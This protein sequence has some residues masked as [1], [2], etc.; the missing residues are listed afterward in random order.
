MEFKI[1]KQVFLNGLYKVQGIID[2]KSTLNVL[3]HVLITS[4]SDGIRMTSTD[5][6]V[7]LFGH[8]PSEVIQPGSMAVNGRSL[9]DVVKSL[10]ND[11]IH[12]RSLENHWVEVVC[13]RSRFRLTGI[14]SDDF[15]VFQQDDGIA[16]FT[17]DKAVIQS[18]IEK[19]GFSVS[20]DET[21]LNLNGVYFQAQPD[22]E[23]RLRLV[24][25]STDGHRLS[26]VEETVESNW[27][28][29]GAEAIIH[30]KGVFEL[31]R[32]LDGVD[33]QTQV[34]FHQANVVFKNDGNTMFIRQIE[35]AFPDYT[36]VI[37]ASNSIQVEIN[38]DAMLDAVR[39]IATLTST[40]TSVIRM[41]I[42]PGKLILV[43]SNP[44]AGEGRDEIDVDY[45][46]EPLAVG[47]NYRYLLDVLG[48]IDGGTIR[49]EINDQFSPGVIRSDEDPNAVF[50]IM[51]MRI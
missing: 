46:G 10:P 9:F 51:P 6:D 12:L 23:G 48:A 38:K 15:P 29:T 20:T 22:G 41:E 27:S 43:S 33:E 16:T 3:S 40:K 39:R 32:M 11:V 7:V 24:M 31:K 30:K 37:P 8:H 5:Y 44:E 13:G 50:V 35:E 26:K 18:M 4:D 14:P 21:R 25:V 45:S 1:D 42:A 17:V 49:F 28:G 19:T 47:F 36:K 34:G 2:K